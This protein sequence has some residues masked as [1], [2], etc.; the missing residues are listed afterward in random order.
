MSCREVTGTIQ[1]YSLFLSSLKT[2]TQQ[3][4]HKREKIIQLTI[5]DI[6][7][8]NGRENVAPLMPQ[9]T[10]SRMEQQQKEIKSRYI[11]MIMPPRIHF[12]RLEL[13]FIFHSSSISGF[14]KTLQL[15][16][17]RVNYRF[18]Q[19]LHCLITSR[20]I[21]AGTTRKVLSKASEGSQVHED[22][23]LQLSIM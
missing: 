20:S 21:L 4:H 3:K 14:W 18:L 11:P 23:P 8:N 1:F 5:S 10:E 2:N 12:L 19:S 16:S 17:S 9:K 22:Q 7:V 13:T 15:K 6:S